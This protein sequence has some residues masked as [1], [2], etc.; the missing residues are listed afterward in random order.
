MM[1]QQRNMELE[2][3]SCL[4]HETQ[5]DAIKTGASIKFTV[6][7]KDS[8]HLYIVPSSYYNAEAGMLK[9]IDYCVFRTNFLNNINFHFIS[10]SHA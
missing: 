4:F 8:C 2:D 7:E 9:S 5:S 1:F 6:N 10:C 3:D